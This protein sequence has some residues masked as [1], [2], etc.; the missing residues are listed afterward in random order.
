MEENM[1]FGDGIDWGRHVNEII[2][3]GRPIHHQGDG[4][5]VFGDSRDHIDTGTPKEKWKALDCGCH[6]GRW[7]DVVRDYGFDY[8]GIDQCEYA[9]EKAR[10]LRPDGNF[11][12]SFLWDMQFDGEFDFALTVAV[13]QHNKREE[14]EKI[15]PQ[16]YKSL[17]PGGVFFMTEGTQP[18][19]G[20]G[21]GNQRT[22][23]EWI[24]MVESHGFKFVKTTGKKN[25]V[26]VEDHYIFIK[27]KK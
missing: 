19:S 9:L 15:I 5:M 27:E 10:E 12:H 16:I 24:N 11:M 25:P 22:Q 17:K 18:G 26:G 6:M 14:Q 23:P 8:T 21:Y 20:G 4:T 7:I 13:L 1:T 2:A 3:E